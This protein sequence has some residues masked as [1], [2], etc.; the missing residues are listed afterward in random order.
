MVSSFS[1]VLRTAKRYG[2]YGANFLLGTGADRIGKEIGMALKPRARQTL[3]MSIP[4]AIGTGFKKGMARNHAELAKNGGFIRNLW[5]AIKGTP[6]AMGQGWKEGT[7]LFSKMGK[8]VKPL[9]KL[10]PFI[11]NALWLAQSIP[12]I[13]SR[14]KD[15]GIWG[16][17]KEAGKAVVK[18]GVFS[19]SAAVGSTFG[20]VGMFG[21]PIVTG[22]VADMLLGKS[23]GEKKAEAEAEKQ[24]AQQQNNPFAPQSKVGQKLDITSA[25]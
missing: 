22:M 8:F 17:I 4:N 14:T 18:M 24:Q 16:G 25:A 23:Y 20:L 1:S 19:L 6:K 9:G 5:S 15:E 3:G 21:L 12:D 2:D 10:M 11:M 7:G 13:A